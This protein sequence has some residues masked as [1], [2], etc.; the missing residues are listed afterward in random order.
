MESV[1]GQYG[2]GRAVMSRSSAGKVQTTACVPGAWELGS[3]AASPLT[4][5]SE[6]NNAPHQVGCSGQVL[7]SSVYYCSGEE[8]PTWHELNFDL[9]GGDWSFAGRMTEQGPVGGA[10]SQEVKQDKKLEGEGIGLCD[11]PLG[12]L[13]GA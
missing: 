2:Q 4:C 1:Q 12:L 8:S 9:F 10:P 11:T 7:I 3:L 5:V 6:I 13:A